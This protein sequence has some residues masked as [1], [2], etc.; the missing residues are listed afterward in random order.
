[1]ATTI[2]L[3]AFA[4]LATTAAGA[5]ATTTLLVR[6]VHWQPSSGAIATTVTATGAPNTAIAVDLYR[7]SCP[8]TPR[9]QDYMPGATA[10]GQPHA[11]LANPPRPA[12]TGAF[13]LCVWTIEENG[14]I[15]ASVEAPVHIPV[16]AKTPRR[17]WR[18]H[19]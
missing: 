2:T 15:A 8:A 10:D 13:A 3:L 19:H 9:E 7:G 11:M 16:P 17:R 12:A 18:Q 5:S 14:A 6:G 1:L 4:L